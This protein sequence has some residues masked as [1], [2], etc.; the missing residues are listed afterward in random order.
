MTRENNSFTQSTSATPRLLDVT[1]RNDQ[2][3]RDV[4]GNI[5]DAHEPCL[6]FFEGKF[7]LYG[8]RYGSHC[9][10]FTDEH[11]FT[12]YSS[13]DLV[14]WVDHGLITPKMPRQLHANPD[15]VYNAKTGK[16]VLWGTG[17]GYFVYT[18]DHPAGPYEFHAQ[19]THGR[20]ADKSGD[21]SIY[22]DDDQTAYLIA[23]TTQ[24][25]DKTDHEKRHLIY[26][27][28]LT[29]DYLGG[30]GETSEF[31]AAN[32]E[33]PGLFRRGETW[34]ALFDNTCCFCP[35]GSGARVYTASNPLGPYTYRGNI[36]RK[37]A[38][39]PREIES[40]SFDTEPG[41]GR[42]DV[43]IPAQQR[44]IV[45]LPT[46]DG[47]AYIW[48]GDRWESADDGIKGH[49]YIYLSSPLRFDDDGMIRP[50]KWEDSWS[51]TLALPPTGV[52]SAT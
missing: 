19:P 28:R 15:V 31:L 46:P 23:T 45:P 29:D 20:Y 48:L 41:A 50:L 27:E 25:T 32:C 43:I 40:C 5:L 30:S 47:T 22:V 34:Y 51:I 8:T 18:A 26:V 16:Y 35:A 39:D 21:F 52:D 4:D 33:G 36:N 49:D 7:W 3:R 24:T 44:R 13:P 38:A 37:G 10:G 17:R 9:T 12:V 11:R 14:N 1:I 2:P 6:R 42:D